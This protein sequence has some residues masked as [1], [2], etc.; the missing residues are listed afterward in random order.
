MKLNYGKDFEQLLKKNLVGM[1]IEEQS[2]LRIGSSTI[3]L[4]TINFF[5][6]S[7]KIDGIE[8]MVEIGHVVEVYDGN[9]ACIDKKGQEFTFNKGKYLRMKG[10]HFYP[11]F[12]HK[13][14]EDIEDDIMIP[15]GCEAKF[16]S[17]RPEGLKE[18]KL[19]ELWY[20]EKQ[21]HL[22]IPISDMTVINFAKNEN[23]SRNL[24]HIKRERGYI[25]KFK[26]EELTSTY[27]IIW[28]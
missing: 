9:D 1:R 15:G 23:V 16:V 11:R 21:K 14:P 4:P 24:V 28:Y 12:E 13:E 25:S 20:G 7:V 19:Q 3:P 27:P 18:N 17:V 2:V 22:M 6:D 10:I 26:K 8:Y 5:A